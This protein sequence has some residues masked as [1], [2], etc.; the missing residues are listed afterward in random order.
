MELRELPYADDEDGRDESFTTTCCGRERLVVS[1]ACRDSAAAATPPLT[2]LI[3]WPAPLPLLQAESERHDIFRHVAQPH[4]APLA[5]ALAVAAAPAPLLTQYM[6]DLWAWDVHATSSSAAMEKLRT[7]WMGAQR[8]LPSKG[9]SSLTQ[10]VGRRRGSP[11]SVS[12]S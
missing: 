8:G 7:E 1:A 5:V 12:H 9:S 11:S 2:S 6:L 10:L 3:L 4:G